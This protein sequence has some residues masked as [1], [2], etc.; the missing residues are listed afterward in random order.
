MTPYDYEK[1][2]KGLEPQ[3]QIMKNLRADSL[4][5]AKQLQ[6]Y[7]EMLITVKSHAWC[8]DV[9]SERRKMA[10]LVVGAILRVN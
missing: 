5:Y 9:A 3:M 2:I 1:A 6:K 10:K 7:L 8:M 4:D